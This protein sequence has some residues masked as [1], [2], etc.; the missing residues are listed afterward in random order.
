[1]A[2]REW[3][4]R[5][6]ASQATDRQ[7]HHQANDPD[8]G[9]GLVMAPIGTLTLR[10]PAMSLCMTTDGNAIVL[11]TDRCRFFQVRSWDIIQTRKGEQ[12]CLQ[13]AGDAHAKMAG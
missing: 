4:Y 5:F 12:R 13:R 7:T 6:A 2:D 3:R 1:M 8:P 9:L 11:P 10:A